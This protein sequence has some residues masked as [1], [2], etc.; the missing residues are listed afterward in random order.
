MDI[1]QEE[2]LVSNPD[3]AMD[4]DGAVA[5]QNPADAK[6]TYKSF[7]KKFRKMK[8]KFDHKMNESN[9]LY[10]EEQR[11]IKTAKRLAQENDR[12]LDLLL[13]MNNSAQMPVDKRV[14]I[15]SDL[16]EIPPLFTNEELANASE[17][18]T[19]EGMA[20]YS[21][22]QALLKERDATQVAAKPPKSL[23]TLLKT[24]PHPT[25][26]T[27]GKIEE[28]EKTREALDGQTAPIGYL[29]AEQIDD[30]IYELDAEIGS[31]PA[32]PSTSSPSAAHQ[33]LAF[34]NYHSPYNWL[35]RNQPHIFLQDGEGIEKS[36]GKPGALRGAGKRASIPAPSKPDALE[37]VEENGQGY[38]FALSGSTTTK[39]KRKR[40][41]DDTPGGNNTSKATKGGGEEVAKKKRA[42]NRKPKNAD[43]ETPTTSAKKSRAKKAKLPSPD[44]T[45]HPF[46]PPRD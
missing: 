41:D 12:I 28:L 16:P 4:S 14:D 11:A 18:Q 39:G 22:I 35:R 33:E 32:L 19:P 20:L 46:G 9:E 44:P 38:E 31:V 24:V 30:F 36:H 2:T 37:I 10:L 45:A 3:T 7:K 26:Q 43:G 42:Y 34:G 8:I 27:P 23:A 29:T 5:L 21:E 13:D 40:D 15:I 1:E 6:P 17:L 25:T